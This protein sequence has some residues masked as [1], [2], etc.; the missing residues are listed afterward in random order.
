MSLRW[1]EE[2]LEA[3]LRGRAGTSSDPATGR[4]T[5]PR[6]FRHRFAG[7]SPQDCFPS[8]QR[9]KGEGKEQR[10]RLPEAGER[11]PHPTRPQAGPPSPKGKAEEAT[12]EE[13]QIALF[14]WA[15]RM[16]GKMPELEWLYHIPNGGSRGPAEA[17][18]F[19][20]MGVRRGV[21]DVA[22]DVARGGYHGLRIEMKRAR[23]GKT[24][25]DQD[26]WIDHLRAEGSRAEVCHGWTAAARVIEEYMAGGG[27]IKGE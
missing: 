27:D 15:A 20:A 26:R 17:G 19:R 7:N 13:E 25:P 8:A 6:D 23:G 10:D 1:T 4:A 18:R 2:D 22:L 24:S 12:E 14:E 11:R 3:Y 9:P 16:T 5:V 21:P